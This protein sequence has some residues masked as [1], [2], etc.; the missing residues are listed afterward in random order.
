MT[1]DPVEVEAVWSADGWPQPARVLWHGDLLAVIDVGRRWKDDDGIHLLARLA[2]GRVLELH[3]NG[4]RW[5]G[6]TVSAPPG[7][8]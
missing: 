1:G 3:T 2:D 6:R 5:W 4:A 7:N 8:V